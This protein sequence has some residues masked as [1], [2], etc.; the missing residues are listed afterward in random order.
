MFNFILEKRYVMGDLFFLFKRHTVIKLCC[1]KM[2]MKGLATPEMAKS[3]R[4]FLGKLLLTCSD[5]QEI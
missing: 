2:Y 1:Y 4:L 3:L 5:V